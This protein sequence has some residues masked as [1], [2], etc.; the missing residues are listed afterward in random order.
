MSLIGSNV[1]LS[2]FAD[3]QM[4]SALSRHEC[5]GCGACCRWPSQV[6]LYAQDISNISSYLKMT[7]EKF[8]TEYCAVVWW[9]WQGHLQFRIALLRKASNNE[10][11]FLETNRCTIHQVKPLL[12]KAGPAAWAWIRNPRY[13]WFFA[14]ES[15]S[16]QHPEGTLSIAEANRWFL[17]TRLAEGIASRAESLEDLAR[18][19]GVSFDSL[20]RLQRIQFTEEVDIC[21][22]IPAPNHQQS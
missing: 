10:C 17:S 13:F 9:S 2:T 14:R 22:A 11:V 16:F 18:L 8:V 20:E 5:V 6:F 21:Q 4:L 19:S 15:P 7:A 12:C 1:S 3:A